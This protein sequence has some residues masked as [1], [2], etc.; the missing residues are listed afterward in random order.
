MR[1]P[2][3]MQQALPNLTW[4]S[5]ISYT[6]WVVLVYSAMESQMRKRRKKLLPMAM[7]ELESLDPIYL[8]LVDLPKIYSQQSKIQICRSYKVSLILTWRNLELE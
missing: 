6:A 5:M 8:Q 7:Q 4:T 1:T 3:V 2:T